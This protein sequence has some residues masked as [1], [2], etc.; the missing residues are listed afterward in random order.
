MAKQDVNIGV[1]GNDGTG[2][3]VRDSFRKVNE[4]FTELYA[5]FGLGGNISYTTLNDTPDTLLGNE[6]KVSL[7]KQDG[8]GIDFFDL[9]SDAGTND[10]SNSANTVSFE[11]VGN[12]LVVKAINA[13]IGT[14]PAPY[15]QSPF[16]IGAPAAYNNFT[17]ALLVSNDL[18]SLVSEFNSVHLEPVITEDNLLVSKGY[19]DLNYIKVS[20]ATLTGPLEVPAGATGNEV[21]R[22]N[23]VVQR[24]GD[25]MLGPL[26]LSDHL[27]P[28]SG[29]ST[30]D[31]AED[32]Q[33]VTK[34]YVDSSSYSSTV[35]LYVT[36]AGSDI[37]TL[38][39]PGK[40]GRSESYSYASI[41]A[42]CAKAAKIQEASPIEAGPYVQALQ[43]QDGANVFNAYLLATNT[44]SSP[45]GYSTSGNQS[46]VATTIENQRA[47]V[48]ANTI[49]AINIQF[50]TF[51]YD[52]AI[53][54]ADI[55]L[56][57]DSIKLDIQASTTAIK[58]NYLSRFAG[59]Q[60]FANPSSEIAID[61]NGRYTQT[62]FGINQAKVLLLAEVA[63]SLGTTS[64]P[65]YTAVGARFDDVLNIIDQTTD[66][67]I[68]TEAPNYYKLFIHSGPDKYTIQS[69]DPSIETPN[70]DI[71]PGKVIVGKTSEAVGR[72]VTYTRGADTAGSPT[73][74]TVEIELLSPVEF[75]AS[76]ELDF[77]N[78]VKETQITILI[79]TGIYKEQLPIRI[80]NNTSLKGD[81]FRRVTVRP[82]DG[83]SQSTAAR[84]YF[85]RDAVFDGLTIATSGEA[86]LDDTSTTVGYY[87]HHY[88]TDPTDPLSTPKNNDE[89]DVFLANDATIVRNLTVQ[90]QGGFMMVLDLFK[91]N[92]RTY[93]HVLALVKVKIHKRLQVE[94]L[95]TDLPITYL[96]LLLVRMIT[97]Q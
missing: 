7:V 76:E 53:F 49:S 5:I 16:K 14:D 68:L 61:V 11:V 25:T 80:P 62:A 89:M 36:K 9:V 84:S 70:A 90:R 75:T 8:T 50:P 88:L 77:G 95:L 85:Y 65:W 56:I 40:K 17:Q 44:A 31:S 54:R 96:L 73:Y 57:L 34:L 74:D 26:T 39:P 28:F 35:N 72:I 58:N 66:D 48:I 32:L 69:G 41:S 22:V 86:Q 12:T 6:G 38:S 46:V 71:I 78:L 13:K 24:S 10:P 20:G 30:P 81:E 60:Y 23:E 87:G 21:P 82:A 1:A 79:E 29:L 51:I 59:L 97:L 27:S 52:E 2:G 43:Y 91:L 55:G 33:A 83:V 18:S 3:S 92:R 64:D 93:K 4:N 94:C 45:F 42:A 47:N 63:S 67:P 15:V 19:T 37:Q